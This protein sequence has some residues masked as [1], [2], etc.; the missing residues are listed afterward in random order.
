MTDRNP[1]VTVLEN[2]IKELSPLGLSAIWL[3]V[4]GINDFST[5]KLLGFEYYE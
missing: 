2:R 5:G 1:F 3:N 4:N